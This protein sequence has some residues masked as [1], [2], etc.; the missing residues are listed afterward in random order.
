LGEEGTGGSQ[1][2]WRSDPQQ[3]R[4]WLKS[5]A[6]RGADFPEFTLAST[7]ADRCFGRLC[8]SK[9]FSFAADRASTNQ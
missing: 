6:A 4:H 9:D 8:Q 2:A 5:I 3:G 1:L 7:G